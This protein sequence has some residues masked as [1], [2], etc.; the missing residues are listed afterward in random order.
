[1]IG[2]GDDGGTDN[3][4]HTRMNLAMCVSE[5]CFILSAVSHVHGDHGAFFLLD[6]EELDETFFAEAFKIE[7]ELF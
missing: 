5:L 2:E 6:V 3:E 7:L 4:D 1:M